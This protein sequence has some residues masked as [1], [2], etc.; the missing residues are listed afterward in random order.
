MDGWKE[1]NKLEISV[2]EKKR[3]LKKKILDAKQSFITTF[4][5][6]RNMEQ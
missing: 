1:S 6:D 5:E 2:E 4:T 3:L